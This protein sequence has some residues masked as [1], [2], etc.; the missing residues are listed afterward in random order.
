MRASRNDNNQKMFDSTKSHVQVERDKVTNKTR[1]RVFVFFR[2]ATPPTRQNLELSQ[3]GVIVFSLIL[4][5]YIS[6]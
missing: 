6:K 5:D 3:T 1:L 2:C 4:A